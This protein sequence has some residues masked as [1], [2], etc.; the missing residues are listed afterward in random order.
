MDPICEEIHYHLA[1]NRYKELFN[2]N[3]QSIQIYFDLLCSGNQV[4]QKLDIMLK[5]FPSI[6]IF[7]ALI[8]AYSENKRQLFEL[9]CQYVTPSF[10]DEYPNF[11]ERMLQYSYE[12]NRGDKEKYILRDLL[13]ILIKCGTFNC[14]DL[15]TDSLNAGLISLAEITIKCASMDSIM[16]G[17]ER[18][19]R[20]GDYRVAKLTYSK[21]GLQRLQYDFGYCPSGMIIELIRFQEFYRWEDQFKTCI[22]ERNFYALESLIKK[23]PSSCTIAFDLIEPA[24]NH[25]PDS[26]LCK[27]FKKFDIVG[28]DYSH[29]KKYC[30][31]PLID[32]YENKVL[33]GGW[34][35]LESR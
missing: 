22:S 17:F 7:N 10:K 24:I 13:Q 21:V 28:I 11:I 31:V 3:E 2:Y 14:D 19:Y 25:C 33:G 23:M 29:V 26:L 1:A 6:S 20:N 4:L 8:Y 35:L 34:L 5:L 32:Y 27:I 16:K 12:Y 15:F 30:R 9:L 18:A